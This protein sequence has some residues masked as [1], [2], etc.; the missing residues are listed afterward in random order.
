[1]KLAPDFSSVAREPS[2]GGWPGWYLPVSTPCAI[3]DQTIWPSPSSSQVGTTCGLDHPPQHRVLRLVGDERDVQLAGER[4][5]G[6]DL[7]GVPF[8]HS[9]VERLAGPD[10]V[11][12]GHHR[13]LERRR[14]VVPVGLVEVDVV[15]LQPPQRAVDRLHDVLAATARGRCGPGPV[16]Q[17]TL[18]KISSPSRRCPASA[19]PRTASARVPAY[20]SAV[21]KVVMPRSRAA[22]T[23]AVAA[24]S[25]TWEPWVIQLP[26]EISLTSRP[27]RPR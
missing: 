14:V 9:D 1:M 18:V 15:G 19:R 10:D 22:R 23:Q 24:S 6:P 3:G 12:E 26:Y 13:L 4:V 25:S 2:G 27:D 7:G 20:T 21:S 17:K 16:G 11:G 5:G 8:G